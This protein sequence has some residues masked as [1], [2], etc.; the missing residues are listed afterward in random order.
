MKRKEKKK[1]IDIDRKTLNIIGIL[2][3][4]II[5]LIVTIYYSFQMNREYTNGDKRLPFTIEKN[6]IITVLDGQRKT[7]ENDN[8]NEMLEIGIIDDIYLDLKLNDEKNKKIKSITLD[9]FD[10]TNEFEDTKKIKIVPISENLTEKK[11]DKTLENGKIE[12][13]IEHKND[14]ENS[15]VRVGF[16][17]YHEKISEKKVK[18]D[19]IITYGKGLADN[20]NDIEK[21]NLSKIKFK[22]NITMDNNEEYE[23]SI[24]IDKVG[25]ERKDFGL[26]KEE[27]GK[28]VKIIKKYLQN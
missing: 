2:L 7:I 17:L 1:I 26:F 4:L 5:I 25:M 20:N 18:K 9:K 23:T 14:E 21:Y 8:Q 22:V 15:K 6:T 13:K 16:R 3:S 10:I 12:F 28:K 19:E 24:N 27:N 11:E